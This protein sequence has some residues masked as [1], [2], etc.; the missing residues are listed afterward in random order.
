MADNYLDNSV[1]GFDHQDALDARVDTYSR[2][3]PIIN[4]QDSPA[5][6]PEFGYNLSILQ[7]GKSNKVDDAPK[8]S[9]NQALVSKD[10]KIKAM[11]LQAMEEQLNQNPAYKYGLGKTIESPYTDEVRKFEN[12]DFGYSALRDNEDFYYQNVYMKQSPLTRYPLNIL[13]FTGRVVGQGVLKFG[14][15]LGYIGSMVTSIGSN[16]YWADVADNGLSRWLEGGEQYIKDQ[17]IPVYKQAGFDDKGFFSK[18]LDWSFWNNDVADAVAFMASAIVP[19]TILS[20][21][22]K[23]G[24]LAGEVNAFGKAFSAT[25]TAGKIAS[26]VGMGSWA[27]I[28]SWT[29]N[30]AMEAAQEGSGV[31]KEAFKRMNELRSNGVQGY[32]DL[33]DEQIKERAGKLTANTIAGNFAVLALSNAWENTLIFKSGAKTG[34]LSGL[35]DNFEGRSKALEGLASKNPFASSLSRVSFYGSK[36]LEGFIAEGLW[37]ENAQLAIQRLNT[38]DENGNI[39]EF[40]AKGFLNRYFGQIGDAFTGKDQEAAESIGLGALIGIGAG[41]VMSKFT[42]ERKEKIK[43][44]QG[45]IAITVNAKNQMLSNNDLYKKDKDN[46]IIFNDKTGE[47]ELDPAKLEARRKAIDISIFQNKLSEDEAKSNNIVADFVIKQGL[48]SYV[49]SVQN[50]GISSVSD[51]FSS[52]NPEV[53]KIFGIEQAK[54]KDR[55]K[56]LGLFSKKFEEVSKEV[57]NIDL[58]DIKGLTPFVLDESRR[59]AKNMVYAAHTDNLVLKDYIGNDQ[60]ALLESLNNRRT[61]TNASLSQFP[62][63]QINNLIYKLKYN[64]EILNDKGFEDLSDLDKEYYQERSKSLEKEIESFKKDNELILAD[65]EVTPKGFYNPTKTDEKGNKVKEQLSVKEG[66]AQARIAA[67]E[68][69]IHRNEYMASLLSD[70]EKWFDNFSKLHNTSI[71]KEAFAPTKKADTSISSVFSNYKE[72]KPGDF[73][74]VL[75]LVKKL[76]TFTKPLTE[77]ETKLQE[78]YK[79]LVDELLPVFERIIE[80]SRNKILSNNLNILQKQKDE[81]IN[82]I[83][84]KEY[85][86]DRNL[87]KVDNLVKELKEDISNGKI[88]AIHLQDLIYAV[89]EDIDEL[90]D[91]INKDQNKLNELA[92][93]IELLEQEIQSGNFEG[94][95]NALEESKLQKDYAE[96]L[97]SEKK[98]ILENLKKL[99]KSL[100]RIAQSIFGK[101]NMKHLDK[102]LDA[103]EN[104]YGLQNRIETNSEKVAAYDEVKAKQEEIVKLEKDIEGLQDEYARIIKLVKTYDTLIGKIQGAAIKNFNTQ[105]EKLTEVSQKVSEVT[106][107]ENDIN[108]SIESEIAEPPSNEG[109]SVMA[110]NYD[111]EEYIRPLFSKFFTSTF[112]DARSELGY[113]WDKFTQAEKDHFEFL[114]LITDAKKRKEVFAKL[115]KGQLRTIAVTRYNIA[116]LGLKDILY[117]KDKENDQKKYWEDDKIEDTRIDFVH[118]IEQKGKLYFIDKDLNKLGEVGTKVKNLDKVIR[119]TLRANRFSDREREQYLVKYNENQL[120]KALQL[121]LKLRQDILSK[122]QVFDV[123]SPNNIFDFDITRGILN[124]K[125]DNDLTY[126]RNP[127][128]GNV[129]TAE[130]VT[131][132]TVIIATKGK[133]NFNGEDIDL[134]IGRPFIKVPGMKQELIPADNNRLSSSTV[135]TVLLVLNDLAKGYI[136]RLEEVMSKELNGK[137]FSELST[138]EKSKIVILYSKTKNKKFNED[139]VN[140]LKNVLYFGTL[141]KIKLEDQKLTE[142]AHQNKVYIRGTAIHFGDNSIDMTNAD[143]FLSNPE[144][145]AFLEKSFHNVS[146]YTD[147]KKASQEFTEFFINKD[148]ELDSRDWKDYNTYLLS[149]TLPDGSKRDFI[150][151]TTAI[152]TKEQYDLEKTNEPYLQARSRSIIVSAPVKEGL[153]KEVT[154]QN[155]KANKFAEAGDLNEGFVVKE[156]VSLLGKTEDKQDLKEETKEEEVKE[157]QE[158]GSTL[159][160]LKEAKQKI[161]ETPQELGSALKRL[162]EI[163]A[164]EEAEEQQAQDEVREYDK[165]QEAF[166]IKTSGFFK[167]EKDLDEVLAY[168]KKVIPQF[169]VERLKNA[170]KTLDGREAFGKFTGNAIK[171]W[172]GAEEGTLY[173]EVFEAVANRILSDYEWNAIAKEFT[174]RQ[175]SFIDRETGIKT[176]FKNAAPHQIKE[177]I[178]EEFREFK[179]TGKL[180][181]YKNT[182]TFFQVILDFIKSLFTNRVSIQSIFESIDEGKLVNRNTLN[183]NRFTSNYRTRELPI[184]VSDYNDYLQATTAFMFQDIFESQ[185]SL[186]KLDELGEIDEVVYE[187]VK[188]KIDTLYSNINEKITSNK[189]FRT[190]TNSKEVNDLNKAKRA[191]FITAQENWEKVKANWGSFVRDHKIRLRPYKIYFQD[192]YNMSDEINDMQ[193]RNDYTGNQFKVN[194]K[195]TATPAIRFLVGTLLKS[196]AEGESI[197]AGNIF[198]RIIRQDSLAHLPQLESYDRMML[199]VIDKLSNLNTLDRIEKKLKELSGIE[200]VQNE[201]DP[202]MRDSIISTMTP[203]QSALTTL[204]IRLFSP[205]TSISDEAMWNI[206]TKFLN[207]VSKQS[208]QPYILMIDSEGNINLKKSNDRAFYEKFYRTVTSSI[209]KNR[210]TVFGSR[211]KGGKTEYYSKLSNSI[212]FRELALSKN[213]AEKEKVYNFLRFLGLQDIINEQFILT[214]R[215]KDIET[216]SELENELYSILSKI[217]NTL[218]DVTFIGDVNLR[219]LNIYGFTKDLLEFLERTNPQSEKSMQFLNGDNESQQIYVQPSFISKLIADINNVSTYDELLETFPHVAHAFSS[220]S[221][222]LSKLFDKDGK[223]TSYPISMGYTEGYK[224]IDENGKFKKTSKLEEHERFALHFYMNMSGVYQSLPADSETEWVF[225]FGEFTRYKEGLLNDKKIVR[226]LFIP[227]LKSEIQQALDYSKFKHIDQLNQKVNPDAKPGDADYDFIIGQSLRFF[228]DMLSTNDKKLVNKIHNEIKQGK[229][230]AEQIILENSSEIEKEI[231]NYLIAKTIQT[232][233]NLVKHRIVVNNDVSYTF[234]NLPKDIYDKVGGDS[235]SISDMNNVV[236][237][238]VINSTIGYMEQFKI[239]FGD[240]AQYKDWEK[241]AKSFFSPAEQ[242]YY[243]KT[244]EFNNWL[245]ENKNTVKSGEEQVKIPENDIFNYS[246]KNHV[247]AR[248]IQDFKTV[249]PE[250]IDSLQRIKAAYVDQYEDVEESDGSSIG[251]IHFGRELMIKSGWRWSKANEEFYQ[252]D[253][254]LA[255]K[256]LSEAG[257]YKY[258]SQE[259]KDIDQ[260][261]IDSY[262]DNIPT[263]GINPS[264]TLGPSVRPDGTRDLLK[265]AIYFLSYQA[266]KEFDSLDL[267]LQMMKDDA[268]LLNFKSAHKVGASVDSKGKITSYYKSPFEKNDLNKEGNPIYQISYNTFGIQVETQGDKDGQRL[269]SQ[270][271]KDIYLNLLP[272]GVP[273]EFRSEK[274][275]ETESA[276]R[277]AWEDLTEEEKLQYKNYRL[278]REVVNSL[279]DLKEK[280]VMDTF[281]KIGIKYKVNDAGVLEYSVDDLRKLQEFIQEELRRLEVDINTIESMELSEDYSQFLNPAETLPTYNTISNVIWSIADKAT[282]SFKVNGKSYI[283]VPSS[284]FTKGRKAAYKDNSGKWVT[285]NTKEEYES[286]QKQGKK[287]TMTSSDLKFYTLKDG[288]IEISAMEVYVPHIYKQRVNDKRKELGLPILSDQELMDHLNANPKLLEGIGFRIPTQA[289]SSVEFFKIK[290]FL[291]ESMGDSIVVPSDI[292]KKAGSDFDVDKLNTYLNNWKLGKDGLP[293]YVEYNTDTDPRL[294]SVKEK[295]ISYVNK[296]ADKDI[297][298]YIRALSKD[299]RLKIKE[300][301]KSLVTE[302][303]NNNKTLKSQKISEVKELLSK[304]F[305]QI[306]NVD[307][308]GDAITDLFDTGKELFYELDQE[309]K[310]SY[311]DVKKSLAIRNINGPQEIFEYLEL[312]ELLLSSKSDIVRKNRELLIAMANIYNKELD[313]F[314]ISKDKRTNLINQAVDNFRTNKASIYEYYNGKTKKDIEEEGIDYLRDDSMFSLKFDVAEEIAKNSNLFSY[315]E[316]TNLPLHLQNSRKAV[317]N[318]YFEAIRNILKQPEKYEQLLSINS[319]D[320]IKSMKKTVLDARDPNI[321]KKSKEINYSNFTDANYIVNKRQAFVKG[322]TDIGIFAVAMTNF[323]NSQLAGLGIANTIVKDRDQK[324]MNLNENDIDLPFNSIKVSTINDEDFIFMSGNKSSEGK[325]I[326]DNVSGY[327][328]GAVD[329]AK[330]PDIVDMG[331]H[332]ELAGVYILLERLGVPSNEI[333][334]YMQQPSIRMWL[335]EYLFLRNPE[336]GFS[337]H[338]NGA[339]LIEAILEIYK[340]KTKGFKYQSIKIGA[341]DM[342][343]MIKKDY[344]K[345]E[346]SDS[347]KHL[348]YNIF[349]NFLKLRMYSQNLLEH[350]QAS[351]HDTSRIRSSYLLQRKDLIFEQSFEGNAIVSPGK[352]VFKNGGQSIRE[353]TFISKTVDLLKGFNNVFAKTNLFVLQKDNPKSILAGV[354]KS[355]HMERPFMSADNFDKIMKEYESS[356][357]DILLNTKVSSNGTILSDLRKQFFK[358]SQGEEGVIESNNSLGKMLANINDKYP[359][360]S[361]RNFLLQNLSIDFDPSL[362]TY[363]INLKTSV[364]NGDVLTRDMLIDAWEELTYSA[365]PDISAF[366]KALQIG[367]IL[368]YG[369]KYQKGSILPYIPIDIYSQYSSIALSD[370]DTYDFSTFHE[371]VIR[372]NSYKKDFVYENNPMAMDFLQNDGTISSILS[373][374][375]FGEK[376]K[377]RTSEKRFTADGLDSKP[378]FFWNKY[379]D[380]ED[381]T[382]FGM[383]RVIKNAKKYMIVKMVK[384]EYIVKKFNT[385]EDGSQPG[386]YTTL[387]KR[388]QK[389]VQNKDF[390][391]IYTQLYKLVGIDGSTPSVIR[392]TKSKKGV[393]SLG[394]LYKPLNSTGHQKFNEIAVVKRDDDGNVSGKPSILNT[395][396]PISETSD[397]D[398]VKIVRDNNVNNVIFVN[399][400]DRNITEP[401]VIM[402]SETV[403][404]GLGKAGDSTERF[405]WARYSKDNYEVSSQGDKRFSAFFAKLTKGTV[406]QLPNKPDYVIQ[407][408]TS[409]EELY[410]VG[411]K[412]YKN[413]NIGKGKPA[414]TGITKEQSWEYYKAFWNEFADQNP[415]LMKELSEKSKGKTLTDKF[416]STPINQ[417]RALAEI[418]NERFLNNDGLNKKKGDCK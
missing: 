194:A 13:K 398:I 386:W 258:S 326:M 233:D 216:G 39:P 96:N 285:V 337:Q 145:K 104:K 23:I 173:H 289:L 174:S 231:K 373:A 209:V 110:D 377:P 371:E 389:M 181:E 211:N 21:A 362:G 61:L 32:A 319:M 98:S 168:A 360:F 35:G 200:R 31:Y 165:D 152:K 72:S 236:A 239:L 143:E 293:E 381:M 392:K 322:K 26:R 290:G 163:K 242:T 361:K 183:T 177:Q 328:N 137:K 151:V 190:D 262:N 187:R 256:E 237:Y 160:R 230:T 334:L 291:H 146:Y 19:G 76:G 358:I 27:E 213:K 68:N 10:A 226:N 189:T 167:T 416:A 121:G 338:E 329:V 65:T 410:Q 355:T 246:F 402:R 108:K 344:E 45:L 254:A 134:P 221:I 385:G 342:A 149:D 393:V 205:R 18:L 306:K 29:L 295:Y 135:D 350:I 113:D 49:R 203:E 185:E 24:A 397:Q 14:E 383:E 78:E 311:F 12:K 387:D 162:K 25:S 140:Y 280:S 413:V 1:V 164:K 100:I 308:I 153:S 316:F 314:Q 112:Q 52:A 229:K 80:E 215:A 250:V 370:I 28:S 405:S 147:T 265:H 331:M 257:K 324:V 238:E 74:K 182:R 251:S 208:P 36:G 69:T 279:E 178:A 368:Q 401:E 345:T 141:R 44:L 46:N 198:P 228:K 176:L 179:L 307:F 128:V 196:K 363:T 406:I 127:I 212:Q 83:F 130:Q 313:L 271:T 412:G 17:I 99:V 220:D 320:N 169:P 379:M 16:N 122:S 312:T 372:A 403:N 219:T 234:L 161:E 120:T 75:D 9:M 156:S 116:Q 352:D 117:K 92:Q 253:S 172:E 142:V 310:D 79:E 64:N 335:K 227:K 57:D 404:L 81:L 126:A 283:Q 278:A 87:G 332:T 114:D 309:I 93:T 225:N 260:K 294:N 63:E 264:K 281:D 378:V 102:I 418:L 343:A 158:I 38:I 193:N 155:N 159:K 330:E 243:D 321:Q 37:E 259:L 217:R 133:Y 272:N 315:E 184:P 349:V 43:T 399:M 132:Q 148:G 305:D 197:L 232:R 268:H 351:N 244:G 50:A 353:K 390:S 414:L 388:V 191:S 356:M 241:R 62:V 408:D 298:S 235:F 70:S 40:G 6:G 8:I 302:I 300:E 82:G 42:G 276:I 299:E 354:A 391:W 284:F 252:Y 88:N 380:S 105:Y 218:S 95:K 107:E 247:N 97:L 125:Q 175:G 139:H 223:R 359:A 207:Y 275:L 336:F 3:A 73:K 15:G 192:E 327:I 376:R 303:R 30:T 195:N 119:T 369:V 101:F 67:Y 84:T 109:Q 157:T 71:I 382:D 407:K 129:I 59:A 366:S 304:Q 375:P 348:Q 2:L 333:A 48:A 292:T 138:N 364:N 411:V 317:E 4:M 266:S 103:S 144:L 118:V 124:K 131:P 365:N 166:R 111:G 269:G 248:T 5:V 202:S 206:K 22:G 274:N 7:D 367:T 150:P 394:L 54:V 340:P 106:A 11:G 323:A 357:I 245:N 296:K 51:K 286:L 55:T 41:G 136:S 199:S 409:I 270:L 339:K 222:I 347:D 85:E 91:K 47:P 240:V 53:A 58:S 341:N 214:L 273:E 180:P 395:Q 255:R 374:K 188:S 94:L 277:T 346:L 186:T 261:L 325:Y 34:K 56:E 154:K 288:D 33:T 60:R 282:S 123:K 115:E 263:K 318:R 210:N 396:F 204:Y 170:I 287:L 400:T 267:Y 417:A 249:N 20:K 224:K 301:I 66:Y 201:T 90:E 297:V 415:D 77:E 86:I 171:L 384:P 89:Q